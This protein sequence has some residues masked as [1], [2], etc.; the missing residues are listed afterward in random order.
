SFVMSA[1]HEILRKH[2]V[3]LEEGAALGFAQLALVSLPFVDQQHVLHGSTS[4]RSFP[5]LVERESVKSTPCKRAISIHS[6]THTLSE[7]NT[8][9]ICPLWQNRFFSF[10]VAFRSRSSVTMSKNLKCRS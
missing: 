2:H 7:R 8:Q 6:M 5:L 9:V 4:L 3:F 10:L 1:F